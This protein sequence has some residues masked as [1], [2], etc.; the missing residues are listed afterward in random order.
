MKSTMKAVVV[1][2]PMD[3]DIEEVPIPDCPWEGLLLKVHA[4]GLC[5]SDLRTLRHGHRKVTFP[6]IIGHETS[7]QVVQKGAAAPG[8]WK[9]GDMLAVG[10]IVFCGK[11]RFCTNGKYE[12]CEDYRE[13]A[14]AWP[15]GFAEYVVVPK[16]ALKLGSVESVPD[17]LDPAIAGVAEPISSC[18]NAQEKAQ[19]GPGDTVVIIGVGPIGCIHIDLAKV[20]SAAKVIAT[21]IAQSRLD[22]AADYEPDHLINAAETD[23]VE[24]VRK[25][26]HGRGADVVVT[27]NPDPTAQIRAVEMAGKGGRILL[28]GGLPTDE[29][30]PGIDTNLVHYNALHLIGTTIYAP[31][32]YRTALELLAG[33]QICGERFVTHRFALADFRLAVKE[34]MA[35]KVRK[36][37]LMP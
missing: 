8:G 1:R 2:A 17:S 3:F 29:S 30:R 36:A 37:V 27:A 19:V 9:V 13:M 23:L 20:R 31:R 21:D 5:G 4:C 10:S 12:L 33:G 32:H 11:C 15:G 18:I 35:G 28:F 16:E 14:Q 7:G 22:L 6:W 24:Q 34:A 26:T 25:L